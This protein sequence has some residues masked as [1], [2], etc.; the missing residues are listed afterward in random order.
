MLSTAYIDR[1]ITAYDETEEIWKEGTVPILT[2]YSLFSWM[3]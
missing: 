1:E 2:H 3:E